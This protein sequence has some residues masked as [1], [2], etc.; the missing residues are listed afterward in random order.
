MLWELGIPVG[1]IPL[2]CDNSG[3]LRHLKDPVNTI[4]TKH[5]AIKF[6]RAREAVMRGEVKPVYVGTDANVADI[7]TK[8]LAPTVFLRHRDS[9]GVVSMP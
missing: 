1:D 3:S 2:H 9:L 6:A 5:I 7:F 8:A 4:H